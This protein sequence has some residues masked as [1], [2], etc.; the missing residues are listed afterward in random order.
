MKKFLWDDDGCSEGGMGIGH[1]ERG[2][3]AIDSGLFDRWRRSFPE[4]QAETRESST[5]PPPSSSTTTVH[6]A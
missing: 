5:P 6:K 4:T 1:H 3:Y 2:Y